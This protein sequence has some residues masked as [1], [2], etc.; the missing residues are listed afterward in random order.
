MEKII[1]SAPFVWCK[2]H[3]LL[4]NAFIFVDG[5]TVI[6]IKTSLQP[7]EKN[8][9]KIINFRDA[10]IL[11]GLI[12]AHTHLNL[13][14]MKGKF[15]PTHYITRWFKRLVS[16]RQLISPEEFNRSYEMGIKES[17][18]SGTTTIADI[19]DMGT[20]YFIVKEYGLRAILFYEILGMKEDFYL[21]RLNE[22]IAILNN[23]F[24]D[25]LIKPGFSPHSPYSV[26]PN[27]FKLSKEIAEKYNLKLHIHLSETKDEIDFIKY[28]KGKM[29]RFNKRIGF[30]DSDYVPPRVSPTK[31]LKEIGMF[32][33]PLLLAHCNYLDEE[34]IEIIRASGSSVAF[35]PRSH[36]FFKHK[37][38]PFKKLM[39][40]GVNVALG[41][42]SLASNN[43]LSI[44]DELKFLMKNHSDVDI[45]LLLEMAT[46]NGAKALGLEE[47]IG[48]I[49]QNKC[50]DFTVIKIGNNFFNPL[51]AICNKNSQA[52]ATIVNGKI[53]YSENVNIEQ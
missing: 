37:N 39:S 53:L 50:A 27:L 48:T 18:K 7:D 46:I 47:R 13:S 8:N 11:P 36:S 33:R 22:K 19:T 14:I 21:P 17:L 31:Y 23:F 9:H 29:Y 49:E 52:I 38:H 15:R 26:S 16:L 12:N 5:K 1:Y 34:D 40:L 25:D 30:I 42:D 28:G 43:T 32:D 45:E 4:R 20:A 24:Q 35:C 44:L 10:I 41:T 51:S 2:K 6:D 3:T